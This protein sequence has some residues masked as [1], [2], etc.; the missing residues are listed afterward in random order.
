MYGQMVRRSEDFPEF[1]S[2]VLY[3]KNMPKVCKKYAKNKTTLYN[4]KL[5]Y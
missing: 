3:A 5:F 2:G 1:V 4:Y